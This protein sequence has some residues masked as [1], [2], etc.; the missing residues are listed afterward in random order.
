MDVISFTL[1]LVTSLLALPVLTFCS[2]VLSALL[3]KSPPESDKGIQRPSVA[4]LIPAHNEEAVIKETLTSILSQ[5][6]Q[7]D[8]LLVVA[9]NCQDKTADIA[10]SCG[11]MVIERQ[12][13]TKRGKGYALDFG[14]QYLRK[15]KP[16]EI[17][18]IID[19]DCLISAN[20]I[21][22]LAK[23][24]WQHNKPV[25][26]LY[27]MQSAEGS[28][29]KQKIAEFAW[30]VKNL[31]RPKGMRNVSFPCQLMGTGM[32]F[33]W[34]LINNAQ[35][36]HGNMVEDMKL[37]IDLAIEGFAPVFCPEVQVISQFPE[38]ESIIQTQRTRW[39]HGHLATILSE[40]PRLL[41]AALLKVDKSLLVMALDLAVPPLSVLGLLITGLCFISL[42]V[43]AST[44][45]WDIFLGPVMLLVVFAAAVLA[46][47]YG[48]ARQIV[49]FKT[50]G[51]I[52]YYMMQ[53]IPLY[54][55]FLFNRQQGWVKTKRK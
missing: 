11:A 46:A 5:L 15:H 30:C 34:E 24:S 35:L 19:A 36:A 18:V 21:D 55:G 1:L 40:A 49:S 23:Q 6:K 33:P 27:L 45:Q 41:K 42:V 51:S 31:V 43:A 26:A 52:P 47:W 38:E 17:V 13:E 32:A 10:R 28:S 7:S 50:L 54:L 53:K 22:R 25:Q 2:Q 8:I 48:F 14:I 9:D 16:S 37:G 44:G 29:L 4:I 12:H 39:E 3:L 20:C